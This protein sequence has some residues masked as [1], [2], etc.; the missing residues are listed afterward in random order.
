MI[1][2]WHESLWQD[3]ST[4]RESLPHALLLHGQAGTGKVAFAEYLA[5][6]L[7]CE[8]P[9]ETGNACGKCLACGWMNSGSHPD[10]HLVRPKTEEMETPAGESGTPADEKE[11]KQKNITIGQIRE[12]IES[13]T[14]SAGR[15]GMRVVVIHPAE[16]MNVNAAN[17]LLKTLEEPAPGTLF[18]LISHQLQKL[19]ATVRSRCLKIAMPMPSREQ[20]VC[21]LQGQGVPE[22]AVCL[23]LAG[24]AP[25]RALE[26]NEP[27]YREKRHAFLSQIADT[28]HNDPL[29]LAEKVEKEKTELAWILN[30]LQT[31]VHDLGGA[32]L[33]GRI[34]YH[35]DYMNIISRLANDL[36]IH[37]LLEYQQELTKA[38]RAVN[39]P[40][41]LRLVLEQ[42]LLS[43]WQTMKRRPQHG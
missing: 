27:D 38:Q 20:A 37:K 28:Q 35:V 2:P 13:V 21:W 31:W 14:L 11:K 26:L 6:T 9:A 32:K 4:R 36:E 43:Y 24:F 7:L 3:I 12:L 42:L 41:N 29:T 23:A 15:G 19:P 18:I 17:A 22:P 1:L 33:A 30:W 39:H 40:L 16:V 10:F 5:K 25:L 34:R 8:S